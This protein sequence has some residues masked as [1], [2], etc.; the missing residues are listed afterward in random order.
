MRELAS[1]RSEQRAARR[2]A[3]RTV[4]PDFARPQLATQTAATER[5][6]S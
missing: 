6:F 3:R 2:A 1:V 4:H 5:T